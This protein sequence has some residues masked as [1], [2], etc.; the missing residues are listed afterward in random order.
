MTR[1]DASRQ[2]NGLLISAFRDIASEHN[3][4]L[5]DLPGWAAAWSGCNFA[6][7]N[8]LVMNS[9]LSKAKDLTDRLLRAVQYQ[10]ARK[11]TG[12][13]YALDDFLSK[14]GMDALPD[15][16]DAVGLQPIAR[17][18]G[19]ERDLEE[20]DVPVLPDLEL[21]RIATPIEHQALADINTDA[22][23]ICS[24]AEG[25]AAM[26]PL[27]FWRNGFAF[28]GF[29]GGQPVTTATVIPK[30]DVLYLMFVATRAEHRRRGFADACIKQALD[31]AWKATG[32]SRTALH[33][34]EAGAGVYARI[35]YRPTAH[36]TC[37]AMRH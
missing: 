25:R 22:Y 23:G 6:F 33:A 36:L 12:F 7:L 1:H 21:R 32:L 4:D 15:A 5:G 37:L 17:I 3:G 10:K 34:S 9:D 35:G 30:N 26:M 24:E 29:H 20:L 8:M 18:V 19:M 28:V 27:S 31:S 16:A 14:A 11:E 2:S 13:F